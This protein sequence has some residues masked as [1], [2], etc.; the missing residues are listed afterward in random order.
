MWSLT[1]G[2]YELASRLQHLSASYRIWNQRYFRDR[3]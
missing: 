1:A 3:E 2:A